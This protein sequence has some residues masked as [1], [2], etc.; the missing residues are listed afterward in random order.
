VF[1]MGKDVDILKII[2]KFAVGSMCFIHILHM[3]LPE[4]FYI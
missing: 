4:I 1:Y 3:S 2:S